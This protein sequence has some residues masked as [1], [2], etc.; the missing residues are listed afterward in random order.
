VRGLRARGACCAAA[1]P[2]RAAPLL[3]ACVFLP[4]RRPAA[5]RRPCFSR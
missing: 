1:A 3:R 2:L 5:R 4:P